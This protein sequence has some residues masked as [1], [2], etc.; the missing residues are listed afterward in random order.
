MLDLLRCQLPVYPSPVELASYESRDNPTYPRKF[1]PAGL[2][3]FNPLSDTHYPPDALKDAPST[4]RGGHRSVLWWIPEIAWCCVSVACVI[5]IVTVLHNFDGRQ[6]PKWGDG[7]TLNTFIAFF[8]S[9]AKL[10]L[11]IPVIEGLGQLKW[12]WFASRP[13]ALEDF[14]LFDQATRGGLGCIKLLFKLKGPLG[15]LG[16]LII[17][18]GFFTSTLTQLMVTYY[19]DWSQYPM[20]QNATAM[21]A[22]DFSR[23]NG[24]DLVIGANDTL[25]LQQAVISNVYLPTTQS[26]P[27]VNP[28][29]ATGNC[30]WDSFG[31]LAICSQVANLTAG[32][33]DTLLAHLERETRLNLNLFHQQ[34]LMTAKATDN[35][36]FVQDDTSVVWPLVIAE[37]EFP[38][39]AFDSALTDVA[40]ADMFVAF[41]DDYINITSAINGGNLEGFQY[42]EIILHWC[43]P[44]L[45]VTVT[46]GVAVTQQ[47]ATSTKIARP[48]RPH[49]LNRKWSPDFA[50]C[51]APMPCN[52]TLQGENV[53]LA[54]PDSISPNEKSVEFIIDVNTALAASGFVGPHLAGGTLTEPGDTIIFEN[55]NIA[56]PLSVALFG[57]A[58][59]RSLAPEVQLQNMRAMAGNV[60]AGITN[61][62]RE[63]GV[64]FPDSQGPALGFVYAQEQFVRIHWKWVVLIATQLVLASGFLFFVVLATKQA[65]IQILKSST[66]PVMIA[67]NQKTKD[68]LGGIH[69]VHTLQ[70][71]ASK[72]NVKLERCV[73][74]VGLWLGLAQDSGSYSGSPPFSRSSSP[75]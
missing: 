59:P 26:V 27:P 58:A 7:I 56:Y 41:P 2:Y 68:E 39:G 1:Y 74:G 21:R 3:G 31:T 36:T 12:L 37:L 13:R 51:T 18:S 38:S 10:A 49:S 45:H 69:D 73:G 17:L 33:N 54:A 64:T 22:T 29:C 9:I 52:Y 65:R 14:Q 24:T 72:V 63:I 43:I 46:D 57:D 32:S 6:P 15:C 67:L 42:F 8:S 47:L 4:R 5:A 62:I 71:K 44:E 55:G 34:S 28:A 23:W 66:L 30:K 19:T 11:L 20:I 70:D 60:A 50:D 53:V 16:A 61:M 48:E 25:M 75:L 40:L 35:T